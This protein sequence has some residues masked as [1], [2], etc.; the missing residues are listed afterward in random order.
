MI[1][2]IEAFELNPKPRDGTQRN[3]H[4]RDTVLILILTEAKANERAPVAGTIVNTTDIKQIGLRQCDVYLITKRA[5]SSSSQ[6]N[7]AWQEIFYRQS[8]AES[9]LYQLTFEIQLASK[10]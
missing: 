9:R 2:G 8:P 5:E 3:I 6:K 10:P 7:L 4:K 1:E